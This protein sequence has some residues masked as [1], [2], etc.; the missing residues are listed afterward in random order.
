MPYLSPP[1]DSSADII[2]CNAIIQAINSLLRFCE[3]CITGSPAGLS[4]VNGV[5]RSSVET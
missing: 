2:D 4:L 5:R 3:I 1:L